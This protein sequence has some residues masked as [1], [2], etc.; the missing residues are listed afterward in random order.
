MAPGPGSDENASFAEIE[1]ADAEAAAA[2]LP[3]A[4]ALQSHAG[5]CDEGPFCLHLICACPPACV[6][7]LIKLCLGMLCAMLVFAHIM[8]CNE[9]FAAACLQTPA[10]VLSA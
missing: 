5:E 4:T 2:A 1:G 10:M 8:A 9:L 7:S 6:K 3:P